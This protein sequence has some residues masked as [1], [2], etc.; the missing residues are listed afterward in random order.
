MGIVELY[1]LMAMLGTAGVAVGGMRQAYQSQRVAQYRRRL[2]AEHDRLTRYRNQ[3]DQLGAATSGAVDDL[4]KLESQL[5]TG[6]QALAAAEMLVAR[7]AA[8]GARD[9]EYVGAELETVVAAVTHCEHALRQ[10]EHIDANVLSS[11]RQLGITIEEDRAERTEL[12]TLAAQTRQLEQQLDF[13]TRSRELELPAVAT[14]VSMQTNG[15]TLRETVD[16]DGLVAYFEDSERTHQIAVRLR[17]PETSGTLNAERWQLEVET[18]HLAG[19]ECLFVLE[20]FVEGMRE[21]ELGTAELVAR[22]YPKTDGDSGIPVPA[23]VAM[24]D[25]AQTAASETIQE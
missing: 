21:A 22:R 6:E 8:A 15:Y 19:E 12:D 20:D 11:L 7:E 1:A 13:V 25:R 23:V 2:R 18:F 5:V 3:L 10:A 17:S 14:L 24:T 9:R 16:A 4:N